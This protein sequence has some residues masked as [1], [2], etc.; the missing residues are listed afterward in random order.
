[1]SKIKRKRLDDNLP[2][3]GLILPPIEENHHTLPTKGKT[4]KVKMARKRS[5][6]KSGG[7]NTSDLKQ[8]N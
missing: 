8:D 6:M 2:R 5:S 7:R 3:N 4:P 1:M